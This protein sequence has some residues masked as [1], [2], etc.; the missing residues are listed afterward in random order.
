M[1]VFTRAQME[2]NVKF[3]MGNRQDMDSLITDAVKLAYDEL[4][5]G[6]V[7]PENQETVTGAI[8]PSV[9]NYALPDD[10][11]YPLDIRNLTDDERLVYEPIREFDNHKVNIPASKPTKYTW[12]RGE[13]FIYPDSNA[14]KTLQIRYIKRL[15]ALSLS[16]SISALPREWDEVIMQSAFVRTLSWADQGDMSLKEQGK[17]STM[18]SNRM[19]R[20][21]EA[22]RDATNAS[23]PQLGDKTSWRQ[24]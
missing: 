24:R 14:V 7:V 1:G 13:L 21:A 11:Y 4:I 2:T 8:S 5:I 6:L 17:L 20:L 18:I 15:P 16:T 9:S 22:L 23:A 10:F 19:N 12:Y 3:R